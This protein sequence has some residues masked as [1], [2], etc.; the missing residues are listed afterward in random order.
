MGLYAA[1]GHEPLL[2]KLINC[3]LAALS[4]VFIFEIARRAFS[5]TV[6]LLAGIGAA[7]LPTLILWSVVTLKESVLLLLA[8]VGLWALQRLA[9]RSDPRHVADLLVL[10]L[11]VIVLSLDFRAMTSVLLLLLLPVVMLR[12]VRLRPRAW[13]LGL[14]GLALLL[15][16]GSGWLVAR[17]R[18][19][20]RPPGGVVEDVVLQIRHRRAQEAASARSQIRSQSEVVSPEGRS[21]IPEA[22]AASDAAPFSFA[23]D[24]L[25]PLG[26]ALLAPAPWQATS[27]TELAVSGEMLVWYVLLGASFFAWRAPPRQRLFIVCLL[28]FGIGNWLVLAASEG[29]LGNLLRHRLLLTPTLLVL[30][31]AGLD[32]LWARAGKPRP[33][34]RRLLDL[35]LEARVD[36]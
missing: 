9:E 28:A 20:G 13:Q 34:G 3:G 11:A 21:E 4:A 8:V 33:A 6:A 15:L 27:P 29:N 36:S 2:P 1:L 18:S 31:A 22:E 19:S 5:P 17:S 10:L 25:D 14:A 12:R 7:A 26:Y 35:R 24:V 32:W 30:G 16:L 23:G